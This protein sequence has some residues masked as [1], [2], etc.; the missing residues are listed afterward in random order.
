MRSFILKFLAIARSE[1]NTC[2]PRN[3][4]RPMLPIVPQAG[5]A[6]PVPVG[7]A[8]VQKSVPAGA[9]IASAGIGVNQTKL[10]AESLFAPK[11]KEPLPLFGRQ[12]PASLS[13]SHSPY[14]GVQGRP[15]LQLLVLVNCQPPISRS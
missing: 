4:L 8:T 1:K 9:V 13:W 6:N 11:L 12:G 14:L 5:R 2:G 15:P 7:R 3:E 10:P